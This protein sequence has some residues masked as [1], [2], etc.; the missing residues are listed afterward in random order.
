M[1]LPEIPLQ[2]PPRI[3]KKCE[4]RIFGVFFWYFRGIFSIPCRRGNLY[5]GLVFLAY[6]GVVGFL[7][8][9]WLVGCQ[10]QGQSHKKTNLSLVSQGL[11]NQPMHLSTRNAAFS[12]FTTHLQMLGNDHCLGTWV[13]HCIAFVRDLSWKTSKKNQNT[14]FSFSKTSMA[15]INPTPLV[16][17]VFA[18]F[19]SSLRSCSSDC[20]IIFL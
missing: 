2:I 8:C 17:L 4:I 20:L 15:E 14:W 3:L 6:F 1:R 16:G 10:G 9:S 11:D 13:N 7:L 12:H 18:I 5:V 19:F